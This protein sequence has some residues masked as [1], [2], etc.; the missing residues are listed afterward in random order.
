MQGQRGTIGSLPE[1]LDFDHGSQSSTDTIDQQICW[2]TMRNPAEH[3]IPDYMLSPS[4]M[5]TSYL[6]SMSHEWDNFTGWSFG[7]PSSSNTQI[8][9]NHN[10]QKAEFGWSS[11]TNAHTVAG[12]RLEERSNELTNILSQENANAS[13]LFMQSPNPDVVPQ[14]FNLNSSFINCGDNNQDMEHLNI[15][16]SSGS[17]NERIPPAIGSGPFLLPSRSNGFLVEDN[18]GRPGSSMEG[19]RVSCK[20]KAVEGNIVQSSIGGSSSYGHHMESSAWHG[21][22]AQDNAGS[23]SSMAASLERVNARLGLSVREDAPDS[24]PDSRIVGSSE[25]YRRNFRLRIN[26][27][28]QQ[29]AVSPVAFSTGSAIRNTSGTSSQMSQR[30][31]PVDHSLDLRS[32][33]AIDNMIPQS[34]PVVIQVPALPRNAQSFRWSGGSSSR[35]RHASSSIVSGDRDTLPREE[36]SFSSMTRN[37]M[38]HPIFIPAT[39]LRN[40]V[41]NPAIRNSNGGNINITGNVAS[42]S[43]TGSNLATHPS[44]SP[45]WVPRPNP[46]QNPRRLSEYVRRSLFSSG[47]EASG[48]N[49]SYSPL[50]NPT[51]SSQERVLSSGTSNQRH[52]EA[53]PRSSW[54]ERQGDGELG[55]PYSLR[56]LAAAGEGNSRLVSEIRN[57]LGLMRRGEGLRIE[58]VM[59]LDH[60]IFS[61]MADIHDRHRDMRL[62]V[63][64][65]SYEEL[66]ALEERIGNVNT[67]LTEET[68]LSR[69]KQKKH[70]VEIG[71]QLEAEPCCICQEEYN[72]GEDIG[73]LDCG[74]DFHTICVKQWLTHKNICP[75]CKTTGL[76]T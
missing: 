50:Q 53:L 16:K 46:P 11:A 31:V 17:V 10:E 18:D 43:R 72:D 4:D 35:S 69:L 62:D 20:R 39:D 28:S 5:N 58:D 27:S 74:H 34:Q 3:R 7:E 45:T 41:R 52:H 61:G 37:V 44:P 64:N 70:T 42:S 21:V 32:A 13:P 49:S 9:A 71:S 6:N 67:G 33:P 25:S 59:I 36:G 14:N 23:S 8:G 75:I 40:L 48:Q 47:S 76:A 29:N 54:M 1:T 38:E 68:I 73:S 65:M 56:T 60:S 26:P 57:V 55:I 66:L 19:R 2:N 51:V 22:H 15:H 24:L 12:S 30:F 63:D